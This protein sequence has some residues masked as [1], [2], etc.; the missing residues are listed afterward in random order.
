M[1]RHYA[2]LLGIAAVTGVLISDLAVPYGVPR[3][4]V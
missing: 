2:L 3:L 4:G 1:S